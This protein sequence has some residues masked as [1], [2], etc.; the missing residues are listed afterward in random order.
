MPG[1]MPGRQLED[2]RL[3]KLFLPGIFRK[4]K[5]IG[6]KFYRDVSINAIMHEEVWFGNA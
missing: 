3:S 2:K 5:A 1:H 6:S 4:I